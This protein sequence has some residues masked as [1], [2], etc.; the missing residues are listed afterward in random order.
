MAR[1]DEILQRNDQRQ[2]AYYQE[3][4]GRQDRQVQ[5]A[6][7]ARK[8]ERRETMGGLAVAGILGL[9]ALAQKPTEQPVQTGLLHG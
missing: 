6:K 9:I 5:A 4:K 2:E 7:A 3:W 1:N 8:A